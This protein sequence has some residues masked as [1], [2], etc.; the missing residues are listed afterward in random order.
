MFN[1]DIS[2]ALLPV[3]A[4]VPWAIITPKTQTPLFRLGQWPGFTRYI[5]IKCECMFLNY[6]SLVTK[7]CHDISNCASFLPKMIKN[8]SGVDK[9]CLGPGVRI[10]SFFQKSFW[11]SFCFIFSFIFLETYLG[12]FTGKNLW[13]LMNFRKNIF[14]LLVSN[15]NK[16][17]TNFFSLNMLYWNAIIKKRQLLKLI[18]FNSIFLMAWKKNCIRTS[19]KKVKA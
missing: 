8:L 4:L 14:K 1:T 19:E 3:G 13:K 10:L 9:P 11:K 18:K 16:W 15:R 6:S 2:G 5:K 7:S 17:I 12:L